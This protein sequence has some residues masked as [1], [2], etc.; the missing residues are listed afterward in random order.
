MAG[1]LGLEVSAKTVATRSV[2]VEAESSKSLGTDLF[3]K[4]QQVRAVCI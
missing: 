1:S 4:Y 3:D 2:S